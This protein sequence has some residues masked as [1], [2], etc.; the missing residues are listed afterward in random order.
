MAHDPTLRIFEKMKASL[1]H[2]PA[3]PR[4]AL[5]PSSNAHGPA[6]RKTGKVSA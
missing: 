5:Q 6:G 4:P 3:T 2:M 1:P